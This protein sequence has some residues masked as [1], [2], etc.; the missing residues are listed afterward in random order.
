MVVM[1]RFRQWFALAVV[2]SCAIPTASRMEDAPSVCGD[3]AIEG[4]EICDDGNTAGGDGCAPDCKSDETCGNLVV[5]V[6]AGELCD[7]GNAINNDGCNAQCRS[8]ETCGNQFVDSAKG[9]TCDD[10]NLIA[11]DGCN[12][13]CQSNESCGNGFTDPSET[14]DTGGASVSCDADCSAVVC[15]DNVQNVPAG[16][17]CEDGN[18]SSEDFCVFGNGCKTARCGDGFRRT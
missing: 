2:A 16:E 12:A 7:D 6:A 8:D 13:T 14:C 1:R 4:S 11:G 3:F 5:D 15:G 18:S 9:E 10:G 17:Q